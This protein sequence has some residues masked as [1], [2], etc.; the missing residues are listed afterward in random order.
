M[1][2][3]DLESMRGKVERERALIKVVRDMDTGREIMAFQC[4]SSPNSPK[5]SLRRICGRFFTDGIENK[6]DNITKWKEKEEKQTP[7]PK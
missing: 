1:L 4:F 5:C 2:I 6:K 3:F 7:L